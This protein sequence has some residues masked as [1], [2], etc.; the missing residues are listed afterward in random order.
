[1]TWVAVGVGAISAIGGMIGN[2]SA[3]KAQKE[4]NRIARDTLN[5]NKQRYP[6][7]IWWAD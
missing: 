3:K 2:N 5:F 7:S 1:M 6:K 4:A